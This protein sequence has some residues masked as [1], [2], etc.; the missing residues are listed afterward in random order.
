MLTTI[1]AM[2]A[3]PQGLDIPASSQ[4][5]GITISFQT[6][7]GFPQPPKFD[8]EYGARAM[9]R[10][11]VD[12]MVKAAGLFLADIVPVVEESASFFESQLECWLFPLGM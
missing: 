6:G 5:H 10:A 7:Y 3:T 11:A 12:P 4:R 8:D 2:P 9:Q 1:K